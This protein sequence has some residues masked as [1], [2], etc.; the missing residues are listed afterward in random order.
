MTHVR[1]FCLC[2]IGRRTCWSSATN[3]E[4]TPQPSSA[5]SVWPPKFP[6][7]GKIYVV[8][9]HF[10]Q[11]TSQNIHHQSWK[12]ISMGNISVKWILTEITFHSEIL[13]RSKT[14]SGTVLPSWNFHDTMPVSYFLWR[15]LVRYK[16][17]R[18]IHL[19]AHFTP[20]QLHSLLISST[21]SILIWIRSTE[22]PSAIWIRISKCV[23]IP[24]FYSV[25][26]D[27][28]VVVWTKPYLE[29]PWSM[30]LVKKN[31]PF[32]SNRDRTRI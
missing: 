3:P 21:F 10:Y 31:Q 15:F 18:Q 32:S 1:P 6:S 28:W 30:F 17:I 16:R 7:P 9:C 25:K 19:D 27:G 8:L 12:W 26:S 22:T 11:D 29:L 20:F 24:K 23:C 4:P 13:N 14:T 2:L 5:T